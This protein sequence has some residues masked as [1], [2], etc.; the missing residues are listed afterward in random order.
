MTN[1]TETCGNPLC[2][3][4]H[5]DNALKQFLGTNDDD[6]PISFEQGNAMLEAMARL[7]GA[8]LAGQGTGGTD[9]FVG[10]VTCYRLETEAELREEAAKMASA[11]LLAAMFGLTPRRPRG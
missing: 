8:L 2:F 7:S 3:N 1:K 5:L 6:A 4:C 11:M 9:R 10:S